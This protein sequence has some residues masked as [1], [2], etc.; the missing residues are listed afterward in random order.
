M[1]DSSGNTLI[2]ENRKVETLD[3]VVKVYN[4]QVEDFHTYFVGECAVWVH[5]AEYSQ[6]AFKQTEFKSSYDDRINQTPGKKTSLLSLKIKI[7]VVNQSV[8]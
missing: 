4:F 2:V 1:F 8:H 3:E 7:F 6:T 5:N